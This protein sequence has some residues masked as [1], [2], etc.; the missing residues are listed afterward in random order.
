MG[1]L[2]ALMLVSFVVPIGTSYGEMCG[3]RLYN[4]AGI[5]I[6]EGPCLTDSTIQ[7]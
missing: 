6:Y 3:W 1:E 7:A 4:R 5:C 2:S